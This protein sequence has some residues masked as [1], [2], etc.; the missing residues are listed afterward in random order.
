MAARLANPDGQFVQTSAFDLAIKSGCIDIGISFGMLHHLPRPVEGLAELNRTLKPEST[1]MFHEPVE[2]PKIITGRYKKLEAA[3]NT[4]SHSERDG[5]ID[6]GEVEQ[7]LNQCGLRVASKNF[8]ASPFQTAIEVVFRKVSP[9]LLSN[10]TF[11]RSVMFADYLFSST[12]G[13][14]SKYLSPRAVVIVAVR[15]KG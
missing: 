5:E 10:N 6:L 1:L 8:L 12:F 13:R 3:L 4:Y 2:T 14:I 11:V 9:R 7:K 15:R